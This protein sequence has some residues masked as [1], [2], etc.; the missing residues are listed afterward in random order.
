MQG[1][2]GLVSGI[3]IFILRIVASHLKDCAGHLEK[4]S[5]MICFSCWK[6]HMAVIWRLAQRHA[7]SNTVRGVF[8]SIGERMLV[9]AGTGALRASGFGSDMALS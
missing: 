9:F 5:N 4:E 2:L 3:W 7:R 6:S 1:L 8:T